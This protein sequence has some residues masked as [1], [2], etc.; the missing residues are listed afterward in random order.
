[1]W[2]NSIST[3]SGNFVWKC[4]LDGLSPFPVDD[5]PVPVRSSWRDC[6]TFFFFLLLSL[7]CCCTQFLHTRKIRLWIV[8][9]TESATGT[10]AFLVLVLVVALRPMCSAQ[11][12]CLH[13]L[14]ATV[15]RVVVV[16]VVLRW[17]FVAA[18]HSLSSLL[19]QG[20]DPS[21]V[22]VAS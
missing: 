9:V 19:S 1:M 17:F 5:M 22:F 11:S 21:K 4:W 13:C 8:L 10:T 7:I 6:S 14:A 2:P 20:V 18:F 16:V 12:L 15:V 3:G